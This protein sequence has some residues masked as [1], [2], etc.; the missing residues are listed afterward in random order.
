MA[1]AL[2][3]CYWFLMGTA[4]GCL[5]AFIG[6][7]FHMPKSGDIDFTYTYALLFAP[8]FALVGLLIGLLF[9]PQE[10]RAWN[11]IV[12]SLGLS[13]GGNLLFHLIFI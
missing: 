8:F 10:S 3:Y 12:C 6:T 1:R 13:F 7:G 5:G 9:S 2:G 11:S 4:S